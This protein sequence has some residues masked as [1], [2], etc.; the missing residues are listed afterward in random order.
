M[1]V[2]KWALLAQAVPVVDARVLVVN[3]LLHFLSDTVHAVFA[4][5]DLLVEPCR[6]LLLSM[7]SR[8]SMPNSLILLVS[9]RKAILRLFNLLLKKLRRLLLILLL[10]D[11]LTNFDVNRV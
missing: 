8:V 9:I 7:C 11:R 5:L 4:T 1:L 3:R 6:A 10:F 2:W